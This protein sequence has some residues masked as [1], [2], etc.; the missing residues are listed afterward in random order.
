MKTYRVEITKRLYSLGYVEVQAED[1][2]AAQ[3]QVDLQITKGELQTNNIEWSEPQYEVGSLEATDARYIALM[4]ITTPAEALHTL[5]DFLKTKSALFEFE[6]SEE[7]DAILVAAEKQL[8]KWFK[9]P[10]TD[11]KEE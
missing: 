1:S 7:L 11:P 3:S 8:S 4:N 2:D 9:P 5:V 6:E 10:M